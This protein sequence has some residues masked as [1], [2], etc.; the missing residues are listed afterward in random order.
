MPVLQLHPRGFLVL[1]ESQYRG[2]L[3]KSPNGTNIA[4]DD[5]DS[6]RWP[7]TIARLPFC[8]ALKRRSVLLLF[9][10]AAYWL[11]GLIPASFSPGPERNQACCGH[12]T[13]A[14][15]GTALHFS[16]RPLIAPG[17]PLHS[18]LL[19]TGGQ[20][21]RNERYRTAQCCSVRPAFP[22]SQ[23]FCIFIY[24]T[25]YLIIN[26]HLV[27]PASSLPSADSVLMRGLGALGTCCSPA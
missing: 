4:Q 1:H 27:S 9:S 16:V 23:N 20:R 22:S 8:S 6:Q 17:H 12:G 3:R 19:L 11:A 18:T 25:L 5:S 7:R 14:W 24:Y 13:E 21:R 10:F 15:V 2:T 26:F